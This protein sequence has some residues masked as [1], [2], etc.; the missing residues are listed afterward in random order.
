[1]FRNRSV[2]TAFG[3]FAL[4]V[5]SV[6]FATGGP[7]SAV[8]AADVT[9]TAVQCPLATPLPTAAVVNP[10]EIPAGCNRLSGLGYVMPTG[11]F[12]TA[13]NGQVSAPAA[14]GTF[15]ITPVPFGAQAGG[16]AS[17]RCTS[18]T[19]ADT[20]PAETVTLTLGAG[21]VHCIAYYLGEPNVAVTK[22]GPATAAVGTTVTY[23]ITIENTGQG[24]YFN[25]VLNDVATGLGTATI[26]TQPQYLIDAGQACT[27]FPCPFWFLNP[28]AKKVFVVSYVVPPCPAPSSGSATNTAIV[29]GSSQGVNATI[30]TTITGCTVTTTTQATTTTTMQATTTTAAATTTT[31]TTTTTVPAG[32]VV[33]ATTTT[34]AAPAATTAPT[35]APAGGSG[36]SAAAQ[37]A[38]TTAKPAAAP[39]TAVI[40]NTAPPIVNVEGRQVTQPIAFTGPSTART[41][42]LLAGILLVLGMIL[43]VSAQMPR[44]SRRRR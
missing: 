24:T 37:T 23:T 20:D 42:G 3:V 27:G 26:V 5:G 41:N 8:A 21:T 7:A 29:T 10:S 33:S 40:V 31:T 1:M 18:D 32:V 43:I 19:T 4:A 44:A 34:T 39:T 22:T 25:A 14:N 2:Q 28:G 12:V 11:T 38:L 15:T 17:M 16:T 30:S 13:G 35:S 36:S 9:M 6:L